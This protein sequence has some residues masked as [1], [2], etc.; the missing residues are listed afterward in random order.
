MRFP[1]IIIEYTYS[2]IINEVIEIERKL[3]HSVKCGNK[4]KALAYTQDV[5]IIRDKGK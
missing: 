5:I 1:T 2:D 3:S 4:T